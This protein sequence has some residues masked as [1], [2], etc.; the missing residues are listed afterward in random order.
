[1]TKKKPQT[2]AD[3]KFNWTFSLDQGSQLYDETE[4]LFKNL[5]NEVYNHYISP[6]TYI[7]YVNNY[8]FETFLSYKER[9]VSFFV[10]R[11]GFNIFCFQN[12][13][14]LNTTLKL[15]KF[16]LIAENTFKIHVK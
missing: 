5:N 13:D 15:V 6:N 9:L 12:D 2:I 16:E 14:K 7:F 11:I 4:E 8:K 3:L 10:R 1:M